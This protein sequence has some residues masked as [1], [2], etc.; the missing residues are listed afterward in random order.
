M[1]GSSGLILT[2][3]CRAGPSALMCIVLAQAR[4]HGSWQIPKILQRWQGEWEF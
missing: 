2:D 1:V 4:C 3:V